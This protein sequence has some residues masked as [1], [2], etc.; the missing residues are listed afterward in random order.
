MFRSRSV[1]VRTLRNLCRYD[2]VDGTTLVG[3]EHVFPVACA[4]EVFGV[5]GGVVQGERELSDGE[6]VVGVFDG[7]R[8]GASFC[9]RAEGV[10]V[11]RRDVSK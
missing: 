5:V 1:V 9:A 11:R 10:V 4:G 6:I 3:L 7:T 8:D 2:T